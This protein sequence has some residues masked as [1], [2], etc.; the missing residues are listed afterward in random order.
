MRF[1]FNF[2]I[3]Q[4][5]TDQEFVRQGKETRGEE[6]TQR[7]KEEEVEEG[8]IKKKHDNSITHQRIPN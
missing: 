7:I 4:L 5:Q 2:R 6:K 3:L 1:V 8:K